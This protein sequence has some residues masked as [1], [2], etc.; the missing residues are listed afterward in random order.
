MRADRTRPR[1][2]S[3]RQAVRPGPGAAP[4]RVGRRIPAAEFRAGSRW[5]RGRG[6]MPAVAE[7]VG[8]V[9]PAETG[10]HGERGR[11]RVRRAA[12]NRGA[13]RPALH[14]IRQQAEPSL[15]GGH[16]RVA[17]GAGLAVELRGER[18]ENTAAGE[19]RALR[20]GDPR[21]H[22]SPQPVRAAR[23]FHRRRHHVLDEGG[24]GALDRRELQRALVREEPR[25]PGFAHAHPLGQR[26]HRDATQPVHRR[27]LR[28]GGR[29]RRPGANT[30]GS[31][32]VAFLHQKTSLDSYTNDRTFTLCHSTSV[33]IPRTQFDA[34]E[35]SWAAQE[36]QRWQ[37]TLSPACRFSIDGLDVGGVDETL[38]WS[39]AVFATFPD[40]QPSP[41]ADSGG[42]V[43]ATT[44]ASCGTTSMA[45]RARRPEP[46]AA[47]GGSAVP[48]REPIGE[49][50]RR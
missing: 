25:H 8:D 9:G 36:W 19:H 32:P 50:V 39:R 45:D 37:A 38:A 24:G 31:P 6:R 47:I 34:Y 2:A 11:G 7:P 10:V 29:D 4:F 12:R 28:G 48:W 13:R 21:V 30:P 5:P 43:A 41:A 35:S 20:V 22:Q 18:D 15:P 33:R 3:V 44:L 49:L 16:Q 17:D 14:L 27:D 40:Y 23:S 26:R 46:R 1:R 42:S